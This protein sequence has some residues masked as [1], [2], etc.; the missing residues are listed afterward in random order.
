M[1]R[2]AFLLMMGLW[3]AAPLSGCAAAGGAASAEA[4]DSSAAATSLEP[5]VAAPPMRISGQRV[6]VLPAQAVSGLPEELA[7]RVEAEFLFALAER[8]PQVEW[9]SPAELER[10]LRRS[11]GLA[12]DPRT[13]PDDPL[14]HHRERRAVEPLAG[15]LR[16][17][18]ALMDARLLLLPRTVAWVAAGEGGSVRVSAAV[19][20]SRTGNVVWWGDAAG[21]PSRTPDARAVASA[22]E[23]LARRMLASR[24]GAP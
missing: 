2:W 6:V 8:A 22:A 5:L 17:F 20:D 3:G 13:L 1:R 21:E 24:E 14:V 11:P 16:R 7:E 15:E 12:G 10:A 23:A 19:I 4:T 18:S 9:V